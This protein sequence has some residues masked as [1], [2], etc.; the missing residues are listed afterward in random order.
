MQKTKNQYSSNNSPLNASKHNKTWLIAWTFTIGW[1]I[2]IYI[3]SSQTNSNEQT[4]AVFGNWNYL[5]RKG[6]H[7]SEY[8]ILFCLLSWAIISTKNTFT[9]L[10]SF[11]FTKNNFAFAFLI[12]FLYSLTDEWHQSFVPGRSASLGDVG[13]DTI[14]IC[15]GYL[16][17]KFVSYAMHV[18]NKR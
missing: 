15:L 11:L 1:M 3:F 9:D 13:I 7:L 17:F 16:S 5:V 2:V 4:Q 10:R 8:T 6:A 18:F 12:A 14:G